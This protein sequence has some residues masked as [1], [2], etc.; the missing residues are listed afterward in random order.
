MVKSGIFCLFL[1]HTIF[2]MVNL[3]GVYECNAD[4][5]GRVMLPA[6]FKKQLAEIVKDGFVIKPSLYSK[7]LDLFPMETWNIQAKEINKLNRFKAKNVAFIRLFN[8]GV[9]MVDLDDTMR[10]LIPKDL[11]LKAGIK[12]EVV[13]A[14]ASDRVEIWDKK[15]YERFVKAGTVDFDKLAEEVMGGLEI[16]LPDDKD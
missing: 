4:D 2:A 3:F 9:R 15:A 8:H 6:A 7:S 13:L 11:L 14:A 5:K 1:Q 16:D 10:L 12:K